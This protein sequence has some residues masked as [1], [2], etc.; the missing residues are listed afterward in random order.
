MNL[1]KQEKLL[2]AG[3]ITAA[4]VFV[5]VI[6]FS[7]TKNGSLHLPD[8]GVLP[9]PTIVQLNNNAPAI[10]YNESSEQK[11]IN[12][13]LHPAI[14]SSNDSDIKNEL[15]GPL[16]GSAG[17][18]YATTN[19]TLSYLPSIKEFQAEIKTIYI[20][21]AKKDAVDWLKKQGMSQQGI[22]NLPL[23]FFLNVDVAN[24]PDLQNITFDA[25]PPGC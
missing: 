22:C 3:L 17:D 7:L 18:I 20:D 11:I 21:L 2:F 19:V 6:L 25:L 14:L 8:T 1:N 4:I 16:N 5:L 10:K 23:E 12:L 15:L 9:T 13:L 24:D